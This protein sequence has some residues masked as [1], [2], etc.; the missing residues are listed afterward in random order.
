MDGPSSAHKRRN[1]LPLHYASPA[2]APDVSALYLIPETAERAP[3]S[4][5]TGAPGLFGFTNASGRIDVDALPRCTATLEDFHGWGEAAGTFIGALHHRAPLPLVLNVSAA[6]LTEPQLSQ[7]IAGLIAG[8]GGLTGLEQLSLTVISAATRPDFDRILQSEI[9]MRTGIELAI[10]LT[11][12]RANQLSPAQFAE[13]ART[14][15]AENGLG[16]RITHSKELS[17]QGFGG[18]TAIGLGSANP[19]ILLELWH[20]GSGELTAEPPHGALAL[21]GKGVTFDSGGLSL[22]SPAGMYGMHTD[23]AGAATALA[24]LTVLSS[25]GTDTAVHIALP[26]VENL[27]GPDSIRPGDVVSMRNGLGLEIID[28]DFEGRVILADAVAL[29]AESE[30]QAIVSLATLTYQVV[31]ALGPEI[32]GVFGR[33]ETLTERLLEAAA[34][35]GEALWRMPWARR[36]SKQLRSSAP[37]ATLRNHPLTDSGR[38]ITAALFIGEFVPENI[39]FAHI[40]FAGPTVKSTADGPVATGYGVRTL[41]NLMSSW[42]H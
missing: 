20:P 4:V 36:Y 17:E 19:P 11:N 42:T 34:G 12:A 29:L 8:I 37:G 21:A 18:I 32:A 23:C 33:D 1:G 7:L 9:A 24:A 5:L 41:V 30:P 14:L 39:A 22:K 25:I 27:P 15:A 2:E 40:D 35:S 13:T 10:S 16:C 6:D 38:A 31:V 28:T 3:A 26:L